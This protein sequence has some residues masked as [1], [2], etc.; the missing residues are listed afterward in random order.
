LGWPELR[1]EREGWRCDSGEITT[2]T[3]QIS[4]EAK[5]GVTWVSGEP[6]ARADSSEELARVGDKLEEGVKMCEG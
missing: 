1:D 2:R 3:L 6:R 4:G 5:L